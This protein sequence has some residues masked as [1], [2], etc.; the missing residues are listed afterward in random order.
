MF[1]QALE[2]VAQD[3]VRAIADEYLAGQNPVVAGDGVFQTRCFRIGVQAQAIPDLMAD[4]FQD[5]RGGRVGVLVGVEFDEIGQPG[6]LTRYL[7][8][9][10]GDEVAPIGAHGGSGVKAKNRGH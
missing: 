2:G 1:E 3:F 7:G 6:L 10:A 8:G 9:E 4:G 5:E